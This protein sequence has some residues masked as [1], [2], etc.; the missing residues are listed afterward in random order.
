MANLL[1]ISDKEENLYLLRLRKL[2]E[3]H[4]LV[5]EKNRAA[6]SNHESLKNFLKQKGY[7]FASDTDTEVVCHLIKYIQSLYI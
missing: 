3:K 2:P 7:T 5:F 4:A 6:F 1:C